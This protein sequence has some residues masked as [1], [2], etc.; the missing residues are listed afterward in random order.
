[1][2]RINSRTNGLRCTVELIKKFWHVACDLWT[3]RNAVE[4]AH[5]FADDLALIY[6]RIQTEIASGFLDIPNV[7]YM[8]SESALDCLD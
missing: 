2:A 5:D 7:A 6:Q 1:M 8:Y 4:H 3:H